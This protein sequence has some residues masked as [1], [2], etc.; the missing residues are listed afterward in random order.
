MTLGQ[1]IKKRGVADCY[2]R[3]KGIERPMASLRDSVLCQ[4][5]FHFA[6][7][8]NPS[9]LG[10]IRRDV[11]ATLTVLGDVGHSSF[12]QVLLVFFNPCF[13]NPE[14]ALGFL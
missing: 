10:F 12:V 14:G 7:V 6:S 11:F 2:A 5:S 9:A 8:A 4:E 3:P 1:A 13:V